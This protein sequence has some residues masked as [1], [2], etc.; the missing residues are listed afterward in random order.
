VKIWDL[1]SGRERASLKV[2]THQVI[3]LAFSPDGKT[4]A[5]AAGNRMLNCP[6][7][8]NLWDANTGRPMAT[9]P[10]Q[11]SPVVFSP[12]GLIL[13]TGNNNETFNLLDTD[14]P[15]ESR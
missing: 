3:S 4:L 6:A 8:V 5:T 12:D 2:H 10:G 14:R 1:A 9:F 11:T 15:G 13:V 7:E